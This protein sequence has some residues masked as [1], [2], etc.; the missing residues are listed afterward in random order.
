M[1]IG[2][3]YVDPT[4]NHMQVCVRIEQIDRSVCTEQVDRSVC[5]EQ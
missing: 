2:M 4:K 1:L 3:A 5:T